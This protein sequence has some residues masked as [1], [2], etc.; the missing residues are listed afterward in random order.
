MNNLHYIAKV[1]PCVIVD[2][3][4]I[5]LALSYALKA[6]IIIFVFEAVVYADYAFLRLDESFITDDDTQEGISFLPG[7]KK[8]CDII[9]SLKIVFIFYIISTFFK[10]CGEFF[11]IVQNIFF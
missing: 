10:V 4:D 3:A 5:T 1:G 9:F 8:L 7:I 6:V 2:F 11:T